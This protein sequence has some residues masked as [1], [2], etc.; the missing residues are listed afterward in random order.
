MLLQSYR[1]S[2]ANTT[3]ADAKAGPGVI[4]KNIK[5]HIKKYKVIHVPCTYRTA[6]KEPK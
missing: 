4:S 1:D 2:R 5:K 3:M 6:E